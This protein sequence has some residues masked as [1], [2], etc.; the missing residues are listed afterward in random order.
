VNGFQFRFWFSASEEEA[1]DSTVKHIL[2]TPEDRF[3]NLPGYDYA[4]H[5]FDLNGVRVHYVDEGKGEPI[6]CL[7]GEPS[8]CF[9]YRKMVPLLSA[10][11]RVLAMDFIGF[12][13]SDKFTEPEDYSFDMHY[14]TVV[15]LIEQLGLTGIT[16]VVQDWGGLIGLTVASRLPDRFAR[17]V[18]M[19]TGLPTGDAPPSEGFMRWREYATR[20]PDLP[21]GQIIKRSCI[22]REL[23]GDEVVSAYDAPFPDETY[24]MGAKMFPRLVPIEPNQDGAQQMREACESL[25]HWEKPALVMFSDSDPVTAGG[26]RFFRGLIPGAATEPRTTIRDAGHFLQEEKGEEIAGHILELMNRTRSR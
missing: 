3:R 13:R 19:N 22:H 2:R 6:L 8:W 4:P 11:Y 16:A 17:L 1:R 25:K 12:G 18:I 9:L 21:I 26:D 24:K 20:T 7:H 5:Y 14:N 15:S 23:I 10:G